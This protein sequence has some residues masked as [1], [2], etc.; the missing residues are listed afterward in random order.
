MRTFAIMVRALLLVAL[1]LLAAFL[2]QALLRD[3]QGRLAQQAAALRSAF[4][5]GTPLAAPVRQ[6]N[7]TEVVAGGG[8]LRFRV[9][10]TWLQEAAA[11]G[12]MVFRDRSAQSRTLRLELQTASWPETVDE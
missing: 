8:W 3:R 4:L 1:V 7:L 5:H 2:L 9:P 6:P 11:G 10:G 12:A